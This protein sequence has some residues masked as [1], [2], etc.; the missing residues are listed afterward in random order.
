MRPRGAIRCTCRTMHHTWATRTSQAGFIRAIRVVPI[1]RL[2]RRVI[3]VKELVAVALLLAPAQEMDLGVAPAVPPA[4]VLVVVEAVEV[5]VEE[6]EV[7]V[8]VAVAVKHP[9][10]F[11]EI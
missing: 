9:C 1:S 5:D 3:A 4:A 11:D 10:E 8:V 7:V 2:E 6:E